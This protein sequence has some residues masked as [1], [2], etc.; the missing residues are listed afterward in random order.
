MSIYNQMPQMDLDSLFNM[1]GQSRREYMKDLMWEQNDQRLMQN[2]YNQDMQKLRKEAKLP[3]SLD[4]YNPFGTVQTALN[5][6][7]SLQN[8][9]G[10]STID[11]AEMAHY[12]PQAQYT[13]V[14]ISGTGAQKGIGI[15]SSLVSNGKNMFDQIK[16]GAL[17]STSGK[18]GF[19]GQAIAMT[20]DIAGSFIP[21]KTEYSGPKGDITQTLDTVYDGIA[22]AAMSMGPWGMMVGGIMKGGAL[23]GKGMNAIGAGTD[24]MCVCAGTKVFKA[25]GEIVNI[26]DLKQEDGIIGWNQDTK[27]IIPQTIHDI[28][29]PRQKECLEITIESGF[30]LRCSIDHPILSDSANEQYT[31]YRDW[32][33]RRADELKIGDFVGVANNI[34]YWGNVSL[35]KDNLTGLLFESYKTLYKNIGQY[36]RESICQILA[37][38]YDTNGSVY[39]NKDSWYIALYSSSKN[40]LQVVKEQLHKLGIFANIKLQY[41]LEGINSNYILKIDDID[42][43]IK[44]I[45]FIPLNT[46]DKKDN[47]HQIYN[48]LKDKKSTDNSGAKQFKI[49]DIKSI[50]LQTVYNLQ[51]DDDHTYLANGIITHNTTTDAILGSSFFNLTPTGLI[52]GIFGDR[53]QTITKDTQAFDQ[54]GSSYAGTNYAVDEAVKKSGKKYGLF[55]MGALREA[56]KEIAEAKA[57]QYNITNIANEARKRFD[58]QNS[59]MG[60]ATNRRNMSLQG[61]YDQASVRVGKKG[62]K[63][64]SIDRAKNILKKYKEQQVNQFKKGGTLDPFEYYLSTLPENQK[65]STNFRVKDYWIFNGK[66]KDFNEALKRGM[67]VKGFDGVYH[68]MSIA[69]NPET[70]EI[71]YMKSANHPTRYMESDWYEKGII[72]DE[73]GNQIQLKPGVQGYEDWI[74][75]RNNYKLVKSDP[76]WKYVKRISKHKNGGT[77]IEICNTTII[78]PIDLSLIEE[79][80]NGGSIIKPIDYTI[81]EPINLDELIE[82]FKNGGSINVIPDGALHA[83]KHNMEIEGITKKGIPVVSENENGELEQQAEIEKEEII[84]RIEVTQKLE[85]LSKIYYND[86]STKEQK[87]EAAL[88]AGK[89]LTRETLYN[90]V[91]NTKKLL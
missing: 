28:I 21:E 63:L 40:L 71:E 15:A 30:K 86:N 18:A 34:D 44:F 70:G 50:G 36:N 27:Q 25:N 65:D 16:G 89:L 67:F 13:K 22:D 59:S 4:I 57:Q 61:G 53:A 87:D 76:Y 58:I 49:I 60:V 68:A 51:A 48:L 2:I 74:D 79:F 56:N 20:S 55:S 14:D 62:L 29:E 6:S 43:A 46:D 1:S 54:I 78:E 17:G 81:I 31:P 73:D 64:N 37:W 72:Y 75:F 45:Q 66:P 8:S 77:I 32:K 80:K 11:P 83:R 10:P 52:N 19:A 41:K 85:E 9:L 42:S 88:E 47:L 5:T 90:T 82:E 84:Y 24:G 39:V 23:L 91:D 33:F 38:L 35:D 26:E 3:S 12:A 69:E 7:P